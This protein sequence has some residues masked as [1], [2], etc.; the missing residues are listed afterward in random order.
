VIKDPGLNYSR[1]LPRSDEKDTLRTP[2]STAR[3]SA[4]DARSSKWEK[5]EAADD[6]LVYVSQ[7]E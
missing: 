2:I 1:A 6:S 4:L 5:Q 3:S 7:F